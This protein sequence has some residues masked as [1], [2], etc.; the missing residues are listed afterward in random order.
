MIDVFRIGVSIGMT[1][2]VSPAISTI[3]RDLAGLGRAV[4]RTRAGFEGMRRAA[5]AASGSMR[6]VMHGS[7]PIGVGF[8]ARRA[9]GSAVTGAGIPAAGVGVVRA[10][11]SDAAERPGIWRAVLGAFERIEARHARALLSIGGGEIRG[12]PARA[13]SLHLRQAREMST[14]GARLGPAERTVSPSG[15][16]S[17]TAGSSLPPA[18]RFGHAGMGPGGK[19]PGGVGRQVVEARR[20]M[21]GVVRTA[22]ARLA[23][24]TRATSDFDRRV[25]VGRARA[26]LRPSLAA[27]DHAVLA[28]AEAVRSRAPGSFA[29]GLAAVTAARPALARNAASGEAG[30]GLLAADWRAHFARPTQRTPPIGATLHGIGGWRGMERAEV[31]GLR[32]STPTEPQRVIVMNAHDI[33]NATGFAVHRGL[34]APAA[35]T[36]SLPTPATLP[37]APGPMP[38]LP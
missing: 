18:L 24:A 37:W 21:P 8:A 38:A 6:G 7:V 27:G 4:E 20:L 32:T 9:G 31:G 19:E 10:A 14:H 17:V 16:R 22:M 25:E 29:R 26:P 33:G 36:P 3:Q 28:N 5:V 34:R 11:G 1:N 2:D 15:H 23:G 35:M 13:V 12:M 30:S